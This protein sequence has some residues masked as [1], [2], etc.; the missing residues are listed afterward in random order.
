[1]QATVYP[2]TTAQ[3]H[4]RLAVEGLARVEIACKPVQWR[5]LQSA[6]DGRIDNLE[7]VARTW[8]VDVRDR[9]AKRP[10]LSLRQVSGTLTNGSLS[11]DVGKQFIR[12]GK[13]DI[14]TPTD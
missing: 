6:A 11:L 12:W 9:T 7:Q 8:K 3:D 4:D 5:T 10:A 2:Q 1:M 13:A 14:V